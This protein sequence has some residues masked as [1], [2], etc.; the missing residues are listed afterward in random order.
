MANARIL[1]V[2]DERLVATDISQCLQQLGYEVTGTAVSAVDALRQAVMETP[3]LVLMDIKLKGGIDGVQA[4]EAIYER[5][6]IPVVYLTA[7]ADVETVERAKHTFPSGYVLKPFDDRSLRTAVELA[8]HRHS[9]TR[10]PSR[11]EQHLSDALAGL[12]YAVVMTD[13]RGA[14]ILMNRAAE[15]LTGRRERDSLGHMIAEVFTAIDCESGTLIE[16]PLGRV[17]LDGAAVLTADCTVLR[18]KD[19]TKRHIEA[20]LSNVVD[21]HGR[22][23]GVTIVFREVLMPEPAGTN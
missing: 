10:K 3:D 7:F 12:R 2:E 9:A 20:H 5:M 23:D 22:M 13:A 8:L 21:Q 17:A 6:N 14:V 16:N 15:A 18:A 19:G 4:A 11:R 1:V